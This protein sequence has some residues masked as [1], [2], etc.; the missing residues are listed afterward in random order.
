MRLFGAINSYGDRI[1]ISGVD[2][3]YPDDAYIADV[4]D[5]AE[6]AFNKARTFVEDLYLRNQLTLRS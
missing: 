6:E 4:V 5:T 2:D 3:Q 1:K